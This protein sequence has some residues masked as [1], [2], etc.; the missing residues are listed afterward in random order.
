MADHY[1][2]LTDDEAPPAPS[3]FKAAAAA[4]RERY[5]AL[6]AQGLPLNDIADRLGIT[7]EQARTLAKA[8]GQRTPVD[9]GAGECREAR[10]PSGLDYDA[11]G[12]RGPR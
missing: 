4:R 2:R 1:A 6:V 5:L 9:R 8:T 3:R 7:L 10:A 12:G 11:R